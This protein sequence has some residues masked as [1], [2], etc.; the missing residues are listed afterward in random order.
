MNEASIEQLQRDAKKKGAYQAQIA[1]AEY[2]LET[3]GDI[4]TIKT[5]LTSV[6]NDDQAPKEYQALAWFWYGKF[7]EKTKGGAGGSGGL[8]KEIIN[9]YTK[10]VQLDTDRTLPEYFLACRVLASN[11]PNSLLRP[12]Y[13]ER[14]RYVPQITPQKLTGDP[15]EI[16]YKQFRDAFEKGT[17]PL[18]QYQADLSKLLS[19]VEL[20]DTLEAK[21]RFQLLHIALLQAKEHGLMDSLSQATTGVKLLIYNP[22]IGKTD[23]AMRARDVYNAMVKGI[24]AINSE[25][26]M[27][28]IAPAIQASEGSSWFTRSFYSMLNWVHMQTKDFAAKRQKEIDQLRVDRVKGLA[29][30][31]L[32]TPRLASDTCTRLADGDIK[33]VFT[34]LQH[35]NIAQVTCEEVTVKRQYYSYYDRPPGHLAYH[36][37]TRSVNNFTFFVKMLTGKMITCR[38]NEYTAISKVKQQILEKEGI[39]VEQQ[40]LIYNNQGLNNKEKTVG[41]SGIEENTTVYCKLRL[42]GPH[43]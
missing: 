15:P 25:L 10:V 22:K 37:A 13:G 6:Y 5:L 8:D 38:A 12:V 19:D 43:Q 42:G 9:T 32:K 1:Y 40:I 14:A 21:I 41:V 17:K 28:Q 30:K 33:G 35:R 2:L 18:I 39:P 7:L 34:K 3:K 31:L 11:H 4:G 29:E 23:K 27:R 26:N 20:T 16:Q 36:R 24:A